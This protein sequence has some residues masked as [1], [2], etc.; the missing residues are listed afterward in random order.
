M[1]WG[2][3]CAWKTTCIYSIHS[4][5]RPFRF[6]DSPYWTTN[7]DD[8]INVTIRH[9]TVDVKYNAG[10]TTHTTEELTVRFIFIFKVVF[11]IGLGPADVAV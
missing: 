4:F 1:L 7:F 6:K 11:G 10:A 9:C 8:I 5:I 3:I 2:R